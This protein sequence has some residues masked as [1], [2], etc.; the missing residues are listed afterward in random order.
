MEKITVKSVESTGSKSASDI[1]REALRKVGGLE[2][3][4]KPDV[5]NTTEETEEEE[6][7]EETIEENELSEAEI[8]NYFKNKHGK[9][10]ESL[11]S[12]FVTKEEQRQ[13]PEDVSTYLKY[14]EETGRG[15]N[16]FLKLNEGIENLSD[17]EKLARYYSATESG[18]DAEDITDLISDKFSYDE[19]FADEVEIK[20]QQRKKKR[21][22]AKATEFLNE[23]KQKYSTPLESNGKGSEEASEEIKAYREYIGKATTRQEQA[24]REREWFS[25]K[26]D[27]VFNPDFKGFEF[28]VNDKSITFPLSNV[29]EVKDAQT[30]ITNFIKKFTDEQGLMKDASG[31]HKALSMAMNPEAYAKFFYEQGQADSVSDTSKSFKNTTLGGHK[32]PETRSGDKPIARA[33]DS[34]SGKGLKIKKRN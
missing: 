9:E 28:K 5:V 27:E 30:D 18:L 17:D 4:T 2:E 1:E 13:L 12:L 32:V 21:E 26:T 23:Q 24:K 20:R 22:I 31:Y 7:I 6:V 8:L 16:D 10:L 3:E 33:I 25:K 29:N 14:K 11:D 15:L 19:D 34:G